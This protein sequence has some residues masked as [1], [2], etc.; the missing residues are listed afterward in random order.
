MYRAL[1]GGR[2]FWRQA[3]APLTGFAGDAHQRLLHAAGTTAETGAIL[4]AARGFACFLTFTL[5]CPRPVARTSARRHCPDG[6]PYTSSHFS[7]DHRHL[8]PEAVPDRAVHWRRCAGHCLSRWRQNPNR[9]KVTLNTILKHPKSPHF[10][11]ETQKK[12]TYT[13][14]HTE[15][16]APRTGFAGA[17]RARSRSD[18]ALE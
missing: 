4:R 8:S 10:T 6:W 17:L 16:A 1:L 13:L 11:I 2:A 9:P 18:F 14:T 7:T 5:R 15:K 12:K 3:A